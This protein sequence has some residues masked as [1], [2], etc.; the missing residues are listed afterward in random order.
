MGRINHGISGGFSGKVGTVVGATWNGI[1][2]MR[3]IESGRT[4][5][6]STAQQNQRA[7]FL[8]IIQFLRPLKGFLPI[9]FK[10]RAVNMSPYNAA[11]SYH[12]AS[13]LKGT[14]PD[15]EID[16]SKVMVSQGKLPGALN[17][18]VVSNIANEIGFTWDNNSAKINAM[19]NDNAVLVVYNPAKQNAL[20]VINGQ[21]RISGSQTITL[22]ASFS[23]DEVQ[24][25]LSFRKANQTVISDSQFVG[26]LRVR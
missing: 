11:T 9:G 21:T 22:P 17:P 13:A 7:K 12:L 2:Y 10:S 1:D 18:I 25:Y 6:K 23:G 4:D 14:F 24:C 15:Y 5:A 20:W 16:Y 26:S 8:T 19:G 3:S